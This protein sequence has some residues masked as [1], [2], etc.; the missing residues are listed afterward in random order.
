MGMSSLLSGQIWTNGTLED[1]ISTCPDSEIRILKVIKNGKLFKAWIV[2]GNSPSVTFTDS[3]MDLD[4]YRVTF[5]GKPDLDGPIEHLLYGRL[6]AMT[7]PIY[8]GFHSKDLDMNM[9]FGNLHSHSEVSD[10][11]GS[12]E[13]GFKWARDEAGYDFYAMTDHAEQ[14]MPWEWRNMG[15]Q[16]DKFNETG[17]VVA[18]RGF[19]WSHA[20]AGHINVFNTDKYTSSILTPTL[21][22]F[23][24]WIEHNNALAQFNH[25]G[26]EPFK[27]R[28]FLYYS[29]VSDNFFAMETG[30]KDTGNLDGEYL[31][32]YPD[33][34]SKGWRVAPT[35]NQDNHSLSTNSH[36]TVI[37][38]PELSRKAL[39]SAMKS[40]R[41]YST[42]D[43]NIKVAFKFG[44]HWMGSI[45]ETAAETLTFTIDISDD[46]TIESIELV[47]GKGNVVAEKIPD[48]KTGTLQWCPQIP[49]V[50]DAYYVIVTSEN[51]LD[52]PQAE[53][54]QVTVTAPIFIQ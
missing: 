44:N 7:S 49:A 5:Y 3:P 26:R 45:V 29:F 21:D 34:L 35:N 13:K 40:R 52:D 27:F 51:R 46:E 19:E 33:A 23:Y 32:Y 25:P 2:A 8:S 37:I 18:L 11:Q 38:A 50:K 36:R 54:L 28:N 17:R 24:L 41:M 4:Y 14:I 53:P 12:P 43:S 47:N 22:L 6:L 9:Y 1:Y 16:A 15:K 20:L 31:S 30:N 42:D 10:G 48:V 39:F